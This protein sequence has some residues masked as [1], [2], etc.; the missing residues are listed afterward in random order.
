MKEK[1]KIERS[2]SE[3]KRKRERDK[4]RGRARRI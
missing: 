2:V 1:R 4:E 3:I